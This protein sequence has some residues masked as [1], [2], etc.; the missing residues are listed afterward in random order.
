MSVSIVMPVYN[1]EEIIEKVVRQHYTEIIVKIDGSE[2]IVVDDGSTD[3]TPKILARLVQELPRLK[4]IRLEKNSGH[5]TALRLGFIQARNPFIFQIDSDGQFGAEDFWKLYRLKEDSDIISGCRT[6]RHDPWH[7]QM[8]S[9]MAMLIDA[10]IFGIVIKD[11]NSPFKL[12]K[13]GVLKDTINDVPAKPFATSMLIVISAKHKGYRFTEIPVAHFSRITGKSN[14]INISYLCKGCLLSFRDIMLL[15][16]RLLCKRP[17]ERKSN[18]A[19]IS[20]KP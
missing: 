6:P 8:I 9:L 12:I 18:A 3:S 17:A 10:V 7:R 14:L 2:F 5:G 15:K 20:V 19:G 1:E 16:K 13:A 4:I 11:I